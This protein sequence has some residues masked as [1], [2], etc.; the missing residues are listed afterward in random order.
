MAIKEG[1]HITCKFSVIWIL[2]LPTRVII[3]QWLLCKNRLLTVDNL[4]RRGWIMPNIYHLCRKKNR[5]ITTHIPTVRLHKTG[6]SNDNT[7]TSTD[8]LHIRFSTRTIW[9]SHIEAENESQK[10]LQVTLQ[11]VVWTKRCTIIFREEY[12]S[13]MKLQ[14]EVALK[15]YKWFSSP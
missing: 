11:F 10:R 8:K 13:T 14:R 4:I 12:K 2:Q 3:F 7:S 1:P 6:D 15:Y 9:Y 5:D